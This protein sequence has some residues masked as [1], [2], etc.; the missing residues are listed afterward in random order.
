MM[1]TQQGFSPNILAMFISLSRTA[2]CFFLNIL[3]TEIC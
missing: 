1:V 3:S 2:A